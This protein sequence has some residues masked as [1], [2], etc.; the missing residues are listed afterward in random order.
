VA[1][2]TGVMLGRIA[3]VGGIEFVGSGTDVTTAG[4]ARDARVGSD[5]WRIDIVVAVESDAGLLYNRSEHPAVTTTDN[6]SRARRTTGLRILFPFIIEPTV[7]SS[8]CIH[9][10]CRP[11]GM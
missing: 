3:D 6:T 9:T 1:R 5:V 11:D 8:V 2:V 10:N 7:L 4:I